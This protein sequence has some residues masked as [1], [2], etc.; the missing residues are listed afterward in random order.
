M[1]LA[2]RNNIILGGVILVA[3]LSIAFAAT[4]VLI[5]QE[6]T[7]VGLQESSQASIAPALTSLLSEL[8]FAFFAS[9]ILYF[10]F[11]KT[12]SPEIFFFIAF[13]VSM[14]FDAF[15]AVQ[16]LIDISSVA[17]YF[18]GAATKVIYFGKFFG[19]L[20]VFAAGL[21]STGVEYQKTEIILGIAFLLALSLA[22]ALPVDVTLLGG[23]LV[24][25]IGGTRELTIISILFQCF[26]VLNFAL[27]AVI[28]HDRNYLFMAA[29]IALVLIGR[30][31]LFYRSDSIALIAA[32]VLLIGGATLFSERTHE[33]H[34]WT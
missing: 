18:G 11:R 32:F 8:V 25:P 24:H 28:H 2:T 1:T 15:K 23:N 22:L 34:L 19:T 7:I 9:L 16:I 33:V 6:T 3:L 20:T 17:P 30:E 27:A 10:S 21:F 13:V 5:F 12:A 14:S 31:L 26:A 29:G 4:V